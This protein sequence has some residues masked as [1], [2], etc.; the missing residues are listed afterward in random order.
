MII[1]PVVEMLSHMGVLFNRVWM[2]PCLDHVFRSHGS[3]PALFR[4]DWP[5]MQSIQFCARSDWDPSRRGMPWSQKRKFTRL[6]LFFLLGTC[7]ALAQFSSALQGLIS[8]T[9]GA[10]VPGAV[11]VA[12]NVATGVAR[13]A[14][15]ASDGLYRVPNLGAGTYR[16]LAEK[17]GF[18]SA[19]KQDISV[20][21]SETVRVGIVW[22]YRDPNN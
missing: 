8:D 22:R 2:T 1:G 19:A 5:V 4:L 13:R 15:T 10:S 11:V 6:L 20:G 18:R 21:D 9:S 14:V 7:P 3:I 17:S 16:I 12:T